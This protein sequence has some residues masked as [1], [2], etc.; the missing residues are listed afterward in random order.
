MKL[1]V[2]EMINGSISE[3]IFFTCPSIFAVAGGFGMRGDD[4]ATLN[5]SIVNTS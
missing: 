1:A 2:N 4:R 5:I 3:Q